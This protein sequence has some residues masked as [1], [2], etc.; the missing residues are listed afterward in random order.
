MKVLVL[1]PLKTPHR[2]L[3]QD[4]S[5]KQQVSV[6][7]S[8]CTN[9]TCLYK[10][11]DLIY[12]ASYLFVVRYCVGAGFLYVLLYCLL[13]ILGICYLLIV[14]ICILA[15]RAKCWNPVVNC[16]LCISGFSE[17]VC[18]EIW[19]RS[20]DLRVTWS[21][22]LETWFWRNS[23]SHIFNLRDSKPCKGIYPS[24]SA[25]FMVHALEIP[26]GQVDQ[27]D[28]LSAVVTGTDL[29]RFRRKQ[30]FIKINIS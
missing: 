3:G 21:A 4:R 2:R 29:H 7:S 22:G 9:S 30:R 6:L 24:N 20:F 19:A 1:F 18:L 13:S 10:L 27:A 23:I 25:W 15:N 28:K 17:L 26:L 14:V 11:I 12:F 5:D 16:L 8:I